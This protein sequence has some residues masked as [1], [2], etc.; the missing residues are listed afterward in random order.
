MFH[1]A[2]RLFMRQCLPFGE[3]FASNDH[4]GV[5]HVEPRF[6]IRRHTNTYRLLLQTCGQVF[7]ILAGMSSN[8]PKDECA[9]ALGLPV[10]R[11]VEFVIVLIRFRIRL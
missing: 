2:C 10:H 3:A 8:T 6:Q 9:V 1:S 7:S 5:Q 4:G 11:W